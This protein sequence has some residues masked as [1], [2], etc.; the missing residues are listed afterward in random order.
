MPLDILSPHPS[1]AMIYDPAI[2]PGLLASI[3]E[4]GVNVAILV[5]PHQS[6]L[7]ERRTLYRILSGYQRWVISKE[8][9][10][11]TIAA[12]IK[13]VAEKDQMERLLTCNQCRPKTIV[14]R[15]REYRDYLR[16]EEV[17]AKK[18]SGLRTDLGVKL[19]RGQVFEKSR[20]SAAIHVHMSGSTADRGLQVL[21]ELE[22]REMAGKN[23]ETELVWEALLDN[24]NNG[25]N[26]A[27]SLGWP[28]LGNKPPKRSK[29]QKHEVESSKANAGSRDEQ[30]EVGTR[31]EGEVKPIVG[32]IDDAQIERAVAKVEL[33]PDD[34]QVI[35]RALSQLRQ[36]IYFALG[37]SPSKEAGARLRKLAEA[38]N[39]MAD[40]CYN[41]KN[42]ETKE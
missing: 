4:H 2:N 36:S 3:K 7:G 14:E 9:K 15:L 24:V 5:T 22:R 18:R 33:A 1:N 34:A 40:E 25:G 13:N 38:L 8:L 29:Q 16:I 28:I 21:E 41:A 30:T 6:L 17:K 12:I 27:L 39:Q 35:R 11:P 42:E 23:K 37:T 31:T 20:D 32:W 19:P 26:L 10:I